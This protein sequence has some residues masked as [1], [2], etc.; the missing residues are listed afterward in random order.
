[1]DSQGYVTAEEVRSALRMVYQ[2]DPESNFQKALLRSLA[3]DFQPV[4]AN[5]RWKPSP[6]LVLLSLLVCALTAVFL[7]FTLGGYR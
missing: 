5:G 4:G 1:M 6:L 2:A 7:Y 3:D